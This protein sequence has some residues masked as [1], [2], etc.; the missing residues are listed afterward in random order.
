MNFSKRMNVLTSVA[1]II[2]TYRPDIESLGRMVET[3]S[4]QCERVILVDNGSNL[5]HQLTHL[6]TSY[7]FNVIFLEKN[8]GIAAAHNR[9]VLEAKKLDAS[10]VLIMDQDSDP[11]PDMVYQLLKAEEEIK[12]FGHKVAAIGPEHRDARTNK[13]S[14]F[15]SSKNISVGKVTSPDESVRWCKADFI[16]SSGSLIEMK[17]F[18]D[19]GVM[20]DQLFIDCVDIEWGFRAA[21]KGYQCFGAFDA[22]MTHAIGD[23]P[24]LL[25]GGAKQITMHSPLRHYY[26]FRNLI[27]LSKRPYLKTSWKAHVLFKSAIQFIIF[28]TLTHQRKEHFLMMLKGIYHG[29]INRLGKL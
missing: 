15:I 1:A 17:V 14:P 9:G 25:F 28:S 27:V 22:K 3:L 23:K 7:C 13:P 2:V 26:F 20:E 21:S 16:I 6:A 19:V 11:A 12:T 18:D 29:L 24:L 4:R 8:I 10:H 5:K